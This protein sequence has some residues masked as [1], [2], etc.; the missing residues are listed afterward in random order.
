MLYFAY[1]SNLDPDQMRQR[2]PG[3]RVAG[4]AALQDHRLGFPLYSGDWGGG[5]AGLSHA[6]GGKVWGMVYELTEADLAALDAYEGWKGVGNQHNVYD[7]ETVTVDLVRPDDGSVPRR[8]RAYTYFPRTFNP[9]PPSRRYLETVLRGARHHRLP[10][11][12]VERLRATAA[13]EENP[14]TGPEA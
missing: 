7:R 14:S 8:V 9:S 5:V 1:G 11:D 6:H 3:H 13:V 4:L 2:C 12:Y 10:E